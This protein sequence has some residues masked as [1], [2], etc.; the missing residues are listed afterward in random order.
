[1]AVVVGT[2]PI[3][4]SSRFQG[5]LPP[6]IVHPPGKRI[7]Q[8]NNNNKGGPWSPFW[9]ELARLLGQMEMKM[10]MWSCSA[11]LLP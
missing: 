6:S 8:T 9:K 4:P 1:M 11:L 10:E 5:W 7:R 2:P 3:A